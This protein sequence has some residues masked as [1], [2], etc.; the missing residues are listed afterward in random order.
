MTN[1]SE[2]DWTKQKTAELEGGLGSRRL[3]VSGM[4]EQLKREKMNG[5]SYTPTPFKLDNKIQ[6]LNDDEETKKF[7]DT[8]VESEEV[9]NRLMDTIP[10]FEKMYLG[11]L[12]VYDVYPDEDELKEQVETRGRDW[13]NNQL[14]SPELDTIEE[15]TINTLI[16]K[17]DNPKTLNW[18]LDKKKDLKEEERHYQQLRSG[19][20]RTRDTSTS[21]SHRKTNSKDSPYIRPKAGNSKL[22]NYVGKN[23]VN[24]GSSF[25][26]H[27]K[28]IRRFLNIKFRN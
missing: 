23:T 5:L 22:P 20:I 13:L 2:I 24:H 9:C 6:L 4:I 11:L 18:A 14:L 25:C 26:R 15:P 28:I 16:N 1:Q 21:R 10:E 19:E 27:L 12:D 7:E 3:R 8:G 17:K